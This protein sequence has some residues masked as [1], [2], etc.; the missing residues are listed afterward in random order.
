MLSS[1][2]QINSSGTWRANGH[3]VTISGRGAVQMFVINFGVNVTMEGL[4]LVDGYLRGTTGFTGGPGGAADGGAILNFGFLTCNQCVFEG[5][6]VFGG[7]G[8]PPFGSPGSLPGNGGPGR[9]GAICIGAGQ[10]V[11]T[12][13]IF[14]NNQSS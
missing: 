2:I 12:D 11:L 8:G 4:R 1:T 14:R 6:R 13:C 5:N 9:G 3:N 7:I 10:V